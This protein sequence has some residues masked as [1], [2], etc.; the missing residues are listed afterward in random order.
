MKRFLILFVV[1]L[2]L[3]RVLSCH[4]IEPKGIRMPQRCAPASVKAE[5]TEHEVNTFLKLWKKI[6]QK[7]FQNDIN[8]QISLDSKKP[9]EEVSDRIKYVLYKSCWEVDRFFYVE[10]RVRSIL[11]T[12]YLRKHTDAVIKILEDELQT[13]KDESKR[14]AYYEMIEIQKKISTIEKVTDQEVEMLK[15]REDEVK[16]LL[17][18]SEK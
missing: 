12:I 6:K 18:G 14:A 11:Q 4:I 3:T 16:N 9:S 15:G 1:C 8:Q 10:Q 17:N 7:G 13:E 2:L 5:V